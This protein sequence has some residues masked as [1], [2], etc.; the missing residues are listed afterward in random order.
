TVGAVQEDLPDV[1]ARLPAVG[2]VD[3][4]DL[5]PRV[6][7]PAGPRDGGGERRQGDVRGDRTVVGRPAV[8]LD[9]LDRDQ[10]RRREVRDDHAGEPVELALRVGRRQVLHV[11]RGG[12]ELPG[13][14]R[15]GDLGREPT[16]GHGR[17][18]GHG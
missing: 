3:R 11:E 7:R 10:V 1:A 18:G 16:A 5:P 14:G 15:R 13:A 8:V 9:L 12:R 6:R 17:R 2:I 4:V